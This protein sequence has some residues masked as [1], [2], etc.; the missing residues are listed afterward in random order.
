MYEKIVFILGILL[1][2]VANSFAVINNELYQTGNFQFF[3]NKTE[4]VFEVNDKLSFIC[5]FPE[6][7]ISTG[8]YK[9]VFLSDH[10]D[11]TK[12]LTM[13]Y[14]VEATF[15]GVTYLWET[16]KEDHSKYQTHIFDPY[17]IK[18]ETNQSIA[19]EFSITN[20]FYDLDPI[21]ITATLNVHAQFDEG[22]DRYL[23]MTKTFKVYLFNC[24]AGEIKADNVNVGTENDPTYA[25]YNDLDWKINIIDEE[26]PNVYTRNG[27]QFITFD[28]NGKTISKTEIKQSTRNFGCEINR[29]HLS[30]VLSDNDKLKITRTN[31][32]YSYSCSS[33]PLSF[34]VVPALKLGDLRSNLEKDKV[35]YV[36]HSTSTKTPSCGDANTTRIAG[37]KLTDI[38]YNQYRDYYKYS[39]GWEYSYNCLTWNEY[40]ENLNVDTLNPDLCIN[41]NKITQT[42]YFRQVVK[43]HAFGKVIRAE[44]IGSSKD[45]MSYVVVS[46]YTSIQESNFKILGA[47]QICKGI[48]NGTME[49]KT[50][51]DDNGVYCYGSN[52]DFDYSWHFVSNIDE[53][54]LLSDKD[55]ILPISENMT[56]SVSYY[57]TVTDGCGTSVSS[58][59]ATISVNESPSLIFKEITIENCGYKEDNSD[60][61][62]YIEAKKDAKI[63]FTVTNIDDVAKYDYVLY[64]ANGDGTYKQTPLSYTTTQI[65]A[66]TLYDV[67]VMNGENSVM[68]KKIDKYTG[69]SSNPIKINVSLA[70]PLD[71]NAIFVNREYSNNYDSNTNTVYVCE[72]SSLPSFDGGTVSGGYNNGEGP[73]LYI[74]EFSENGIRWTQIGTS[75]LTSPSLNEGSMNVTGDLYIRR[76][77]RS[78]SQLDDSQYMELSSSFINVKVYKEPV[79]QML[80]SKDEETYSSKSVDICYGDM[81]Y[82]KVQQDGEFSTQY[83]AD[84]Q[85][86]NIEYTIY[87]PDDESSK[88]VKSNNQKLTKNAVIT[89][90][91]EFC[92]SKVTSTNEVNVIVGKDLTVKPEDLQY[93]DCILEGGNVTVLFK[94]HSIDE[95]YYFLDANKEVLSESY[96]V[97]IQIPDNIG[98]DYVPFYAARVVDGCSSPTLI[99]NL[100][101][102][103]IQ[104]KLT[105]TNL[106]VTGAEKVKDNEYTICAGNTVSLKR[107][108]TSDNL[109]YTWLKDNVILEESSSAINLLFDKPDE[110]Y[111][112]S[113]ETNHKSCKD[114]ITENV[115]ITTKDNIKVLES[116]LKVSENTVCYG[117]SVAFT[118]DPSSISGGSGKY[119]Y[120]WYRSLDNKT[121]SE[122][123][124]SNGQQ[125]SLSVGSLLQDTYFKLKVLDN[126]CN[127]EIYFYEYIPSLIKVNPSLEIES[128]QLTVEPEVFS[129][130]DGNTSYPVSIHD[131]DINMDKDLFY[132]NGEKVDSRAKTTSG[133]DY[134]FVISEEVAKTGEIGYCV[135]R[136]KE[137]T[138]AKTCESKMYC[139]TIRVNQGFTSDFLITNE[140]EISKCASTSTVLT[141]EQLPQ[142]DNADL[143]GKEVAYQWMKRLSTSSSWATI[144]KATTSTLEVTPDATGND[145]V[146][147]CKLTYSPN[148]STK[149]VSILSNEI[150]VNGYKTLP[151][152]NVYVTKEDGSHTQTI[153]VC[154]G[155][156]VDLVFENSLNTEEGDIN[157]V[158]Y[159]WEIKTG[160]SEWSEIVNTN[161]ISGSDENILH[162][163][164]DEITENTMIRCVVTDQCNNQQNSSNYVLISINNSGSF[165]ANDIIMLSDKVISDDMETLQ[166]SIP[167][168]VKNTYFWYSTP[169]KNASGNPVS[170]NKSEDILPN[171]TA[172]ELKSFYEAGTHVLNVY[173][174]NPAGCKSDVISY[175]YTLYDKLTINYVYTSSPKTICSNSQD[176]YDVRIQNISGGTGEYVVDWYYKTKSMQGF[177]LLKK[178]GD[179]FNF[180]FDDDAIINISGLKETT[181]FY[182]KVSSVGY[183]G[184]SVLSNIV[185][186]DVYDAIEPGEIDGT[187]E[188]TCYGSYVAIKN[189]QSASKGSGSYSYTWE[190]STDSGETW[191]K[192]DG[193]TGPDY[194]PN[195]NSYNMYANSLYR[196]VAT[197]ET[198]KMSVISNA[199]TFF[200]C[201]E[202]VIDSADVSAPIGVEEG[203][204]AYIYGTDPNFSYVWYKNDGYTPLDTT[205]GD[206]AFVTEKLYAKTL[207]YVR[208]LNQQGCLSDNRLLVT[209]NVFSKLNG[210][211]IEFDRFPKVNEQVAWVCSGSSIGRISNYGDAP[212]GL[213]L[214]YMWFYI[215]D[216]KEY[217]LKTESLDSIATMT[218]NMDTCSLVMNNMSGK[219]D[220]YQIYRRT[221][222]TDQFGGIKTANSDTLTVYV[223]PTL[224]SVN[225]KSIL[226]IA[227]TLE[228]D[229]QV[230]C[231]H[232]TGA[233]INLSLTETVEEAWINSNFGAL[234][235]GNSLIT[236]FEQA[237]GIGNNAV[238]WKSIISSDYTSSSIYPH[239]Y[240][241]DD[242]DK[243][244][245]IRFTIN[246]GC[247][248]ISSNVISQKA[249]AI[250]DVHDSLF[251]MTNL[252]DNEEVTDGIEEGD[253]IKIV[254]NKQGWDYYWFGD[255]ESTDTLANMRFVTIEDL[256]YYQDLYLQIY[257]EQ[258]G[259]K[260]KSH[261]VPLTIYPA[262][263]GGLIFK[264]QTICMDKSYE[265]L[266][267]L[268]AATGS[269]GNF[270]YSWQLSPNKTTWINIT[271]ATSSDLD[272][273]LINQAAIYPAQYV[274]RLATNEFGRVVYSDTL[275]LNHYDAIQ[276]GSICFA[277]SSIKKNFCEYEQMPLIT[278]T[279]PTGGKSGAEDFLYKIGWEYSIDGEEFQTLYSPVY[280]QTTVDPNAILILHNVDRSTSRKLSVRAVYVD[281]ECGSA[282]SNVMEMVLFP[283]TTAPSIYQLKDSCESQR[284]TVEV[285]DKENYNYMWFVIDPDGTTSWE[286]TGIFSKTL[287][288]TN[289]FDVLQYGIIGTDLQTGCLTDTT[290]F[291]LALPVLSQSDITMI[292][293][294]CYNSDFILSC[295]VYGGTGDKFYQW[296]YSYDDINYFD[297][298]NATSSTLSYSNIK[299]NTYFRRIVNDLCESDTSLSY[300][301]AVREESFIDSLQIN[302]RVCAN[303]KFSVN[304]PALDPTDSAHVAKMQEYVFYVVDE[305]NFDIDALYQ[306]RKNLSTSVPYLAKLQ[307]EPDGSSYVVNVNGFS[308]P[309]HKFNLVQMNKRNV[310]DC[311][312]ILPFTAYLA[313]EINPDNNVVSC[314]NPIGCNGE[315]I[316]I[317][318]DS[319]ELTQYHKNFK[320]SW[321]TSTDGSE[322]TLLNNPST[323]LDIILDDTLYVKRITNNGCAGHESNVIKLVGN[324]NDSIDYSSEL[325]MTITTILNDSSDIVQTYCTA[326]ENV[327]Q[328][329]TFEGDGELPMMKHGADT[330]AYSSDQFHFTTIY[331]RRTDICAYANRIFPI[332]GGRI[333]VDGD[334]LVCPNTPVPTIIATNVVGGEGSYTYQWQYRNNYTNDFVNIEGATEKSLT[335]SSLATTTDFRRI[336]YSGMYSCISNVV[337]IKIA[338][339]SV[340]GNV[341]ANI[342][343]AY[344]DAH[345]LT[346]LDNYVDVNRG[347]SVELSVTANNENSSVLGRWM[348]YENKEY[349]E[350]QKCL[351]SEDGSFKL[352]V[353]AGEPNSIKSVRFIAV[354]PCKSDTLDPF[355]I[356]TIDD[357]IILEEDIVVNDNVCPGEDIFV[358]CFDSPAHESNSNSE[359]TYTYSG[360]DG[361]MIDDG[362]NWYIEDNKKT[363]NGVRLKNVQESFTLTIT[364]ISEDRNISTSYDLKIKVKEKVSVDYQSEIGLS[365][366]TIL[367]DS[368]ELV[369]YNCTASSEVLKD[370]SLVDNSNSSTNILKYGTDTFNYLSDE[371]RYRK[372]YIQK[373][374]VC[375]DGE[376]ILPISGGRIYINGINLACPLSDVP[377][378]N[379]SQCDGATGTYTYQWQYRN[380]YTNDFVNID[381]ATDKNYQPSNL[382][383]TT[384]FRRITQSG[385]YSC[386]SNVLTIQVVEPST[387]GQ[388]S[389][390]I[391][392][393]YYMDHNM[394]F[395]DNYIDVRKDAEVTL[396][397]TASNPTVPVTARW[398]L[399]DDSYS[400]EYI[401]TEISNVDDE[402]RYVITIPANDPNYSKK[403]RFVLTTMCTKD[404]S[405]TFVIHTIPDPVIYTE[406]IVLKDNTCP[407]NDVYVR[408]YDD[409]THVTDNESEFTYIYSGYEGLMVDAQSGKEVNDTTQTKYGVYLKNVKEPF[410]LH[411]TRIST[412]HN[413]SSSISVNVKVS[414]IKADFDFEVNDNVY[415]ANESVQIQQGDL[416]KFYNRTDS[417][418]TFDWNL[419]DP[420]NTQYTADPYG[421]YSH[422]ENP[423][424][425]F[426]NKGDYNVRLIVENDKGC[427]DTTFCKLTINEASVKNMK[428]EGNFFIDSDDEEVI[429]Y[430]DNVYIY[431]NPVK[432]WLYV[433]TEDDAELFLYD[434]SGIMLQ[435]LFGNKETSIDMRKYDLGV[436][437]LKVNGKTF[438][439]IKQ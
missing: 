102:N 165:S 174:V 82:L 261:K 7:E 52:N 414:T 366:T 412:K 218:V 304:L 340:I 404:T 36:C 426:Y 242:V 399:F 268:Q 237:E 282:Y 16:P 44:S 29:N 358:R 20:L 139:G 379:A 327:L 199:K 49:V 234:K 79:L 167:S 233:K 273:A 272:N 67:I 228:C 318:G 324:K 158:T 23:T 320:F 184:P 372:F 8:W 302:D 439:I 285:T 291:S 35:T 26:S 335:Y 219:D 194:L 46:P 385:M 45:F 126:T 350:T 360:Y 396:F 221:Y 357:P 429:T 436:Y 329:Y 163:V 213:N 180:E 66:A 181:E 381:N 110:K 56:S 384:E 27:A 53:D 114:K 331:I 119:N 406:D 137:L 195:S 312:H 10:H 387:I 413:L 336:T 71:G 270:T 87:Y 405:D 37:V 131:D 64:M 121:Y 390:I 423:I 239:N 321:Q 54:I 38:D 83:K 170:F 147:A 349:V 12:S 264:G 216:D 207:Y 30:N 253:D 415:N 391:D 348:I 178:G 111:T 323:S 101:Q 417:V 402:G 133:I 93:S 375:T 129:L 427:T 346:Y 51:L 309:Y 248:S 363:K 2:V 281:Y 217:R 422:R 298:P 91:R 48:Y 369:Q 428:M 159:Q 311:Y 169:E 250:E 116:A 118:L 124:G 394:T 41:N 109:E 365:V 173:S 275:L 376:R 201:E 430:N 47:T 370:Y 95:S 284:V 39:Y 292:D 307:Y 351:R 108:E 202:V 215:K 193:Q 362:T 3:T 152:Y 141:M 65:P 89:T 122:E 162:W 73:Y 179:I 377:T 244:Y 143:T 191:E 290:F 224:S 155:D 301:V 72:G 175:S 206:E 222:S 401:G 236:S 397:V 100:D 294:L 172:G 14:R 200:V 271:N 98:D 78:V 88:L 190:K 437:L 104:K 232:S 313:T 105:E 177:A 15:N 354:T 212:S 231:P 306:Y 383:S 332:S 296:Q 75:D 419:I 103:I 389:T 424:C 245:S 171:E 157:D 229:Q 227:G 410:M 347:L 263:K 265:L 258:T 185:S 94:D 325:G 345:K 243:N 267:N 208:K 416:V 277:D 355:T 57:V 80:V 11:F 341:T 240:A 319:V 392:T 166:F 188:V 62:F 315:E 333:Y 140:G 34:V 386:I 18:C 359:F 295:D 303:Q 408:C 356:H 99:K 125:G 17:S 176:K 343:T 42:T 251:V 328:N 123:P 314:E 266:E 192:I 344:Y 196:R 256:P 274:R 308:E 438:K 287:T 288:R 255:Q 84:E 338:T 151:N 145:Y 226:D 113:L 214:S 373:N 154:K 300:L 434:A 92:N 127:N 418:K 22:M 77:V 138:T 297:E 225:S 220:I 61:S 425:Y 132:L 161:K 326:F 361:T 33:E 269:T 32:L 252:K 144:S 435:T 58:N 85:L 156:A 364:R 70:N 342:D 299:T 421:L 247:S 31:N 117:E 257:D 43:S 160:N 278:T 230:Y 262:S 367:N 24:D 205:K 1:G 150:V 241:I 40:K 334:S 146:Y 235:Y 106:V 183:P 182:A 393:A 13:T 411:I 19:N 259:C 25:I 86:G 198:C 431:P 395:S 68:I 96:S 186:I 134:T 135:Q 107:S 120:Q 90:S 50:S 403:V 153:F 223:V 136:I 128:D 97:D 238:D 112:I 164:K 371:F 9:K 74:W 142:Y 280:S 330:F 276:P 63:G 60:Y 187:D 317:V 4:D 59:K 204:M 310:V 420:L 5:T 210:G 254:Y 115:I 55:K 28:V 286:Q 69:C 432:D 368:S 352:T 433:Y 209:I 203:D 293:T 279:M 249:I 398:M 378:I 353:P 339:P 81:V 21:V 189:M 283:S 388:V 211:K 6:W 322:Y 289:E 246:D 130:V 374:T 382:E 407:G 149:S 76:T 260:G 409:K 168:D 316:T 380:Q 148:A 400:D 305:E 337:T 197:D